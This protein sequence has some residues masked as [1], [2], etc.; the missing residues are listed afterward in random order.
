M[1]VVFVTLVGG[2]G[3]RPVVVAVVRMSLASG[4][5]PWSRMRF[6][7]AHVSVFRGSLFPAREGGRL[8]L[9][10]ASGMVISSMGRCPVRRGE[11][12]RDLSCQSENHQNPTETYIYLDL[13]SIII[14][15]INTPYLRLFLA[16]K[17]SS[18]S[19]EI[20]MLLLASLCPSSASAFSPK[21]IVQNERF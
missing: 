11:R 17:S 10:V 12:L 15:K 18:C 13:R 20:P 21:T 6:Y 14:I 2:V 1:G 19:T 16:I 9:P 4:M 8:R 5:I 3:R 7:V